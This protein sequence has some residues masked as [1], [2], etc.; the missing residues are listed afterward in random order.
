MLE[1]GAEGGGVGIPAVYSLNDHEF[2]WAAIADFDGAGFPSFV[3]SD[4][5]TGLFFSNNGDGTFTYQTPPSTPSYP[6]LRFPFAFPTRTGGP[7]DLVNH[8]VGGD[9]NV[10]LNQRNP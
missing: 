10:R 6:N 5:N 8:A 1:H 4:G 2:Y 3:V 9:L 7:A